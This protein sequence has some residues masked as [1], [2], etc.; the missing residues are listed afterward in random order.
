MPLHPA[1]QHRP[2]WPQPCPSLSQVT[3]FWSLSASRVPG[4]LVVSSPM[5]LAS[6]TLATA[7]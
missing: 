4:I 3:L 1:L 5:S 7:G 6:V 2:F